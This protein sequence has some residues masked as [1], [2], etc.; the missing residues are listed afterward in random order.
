MAIQIKFLLLQKS[1]LMYEVA[2]R[3]ESPSDN[4]A[5]LRRQVNKLTQLYPSDDIIDSVYD[6]S[7]DIEGVQETLE[8]IKTN[9]DLLK[10]NFNEPLFNRTKSLLHHLFYRLQ[11]IE[12]PETVDET[13]LLK[14][15]KKCYETFYENLVTLPGSKIREPKDLASTSADDSLPTN[16]PNISGLNISVSC[17]RGLVGEFAKLKYDGKTCVRSFIQKIEEFRL[18]KEKDATDGLTP[19][20]NKKKE[21]KTGLGK[22]KKKILR[23]S[24]SEAEDDKSIKDKS[25]AVKKK[26]MKRKPNKRNVQNKTRN[27]NKKRKV[28]KIKNCDQT[29]ETESKD[30]NV[31]PYA[32]DSDDDYSE[33]GLNIDNRWYCFVCQR[34]QILSMRLCISCKRYVHETCS[35]LTNQ[36][37]EPYICHECED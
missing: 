37:D 25:I 34:E 27:A 1:E 3:G 22:I 4:V 32:D 12:K 35:G 23:S 21:G 15:C 10:N 9:L 36:D 11:R 24:E 28:F 31:I 8:K 16:V 2:I 5:G 7:D 30:E 26:P 33:E 14:K 6:F 18:S 20:K 17:D 29:I 19:K 13:S